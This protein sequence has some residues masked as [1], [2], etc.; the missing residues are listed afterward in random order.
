MNRIDL[1][2]IQSIKDYPCISI[3]MP[4]HR[5]HPE[6]KQD[7]IR[8]KNLIKEAEKR[9]SKELSGAETK[10][11][12]NKLN[13]LSDTIDF[14]Y[15]LDGLALFVSK[16]HSYK[17]IFP[18]PVKERV[19]IDPTF[20]TRD[21]VFAINR[22][23]PYY[24]LLLNDKLSRIFLGVRENIDEISSNGFP[25]YN[26]FIQMI[27]N[28]ETQHTNDRLQENAEK[29]KNYFREVD[30]ELRKI[31]NE[32]EYPVILAGV[33]K[34]IAVFKEITSHPE[35]VITAIKGNYDKT[36][37]LEFTRLIWPEAKRGFAEMRKQVLK[38]LD[39]SMGMK[40]AATGI[41]EVWKTANEG[42][43]ETLVVETNFQYP[44]KI[45]ESGMQLIPLKASDKI[46]SLD[47]AVDEII[48]SVISKGGKVHFVKNGELEKYGHIA[49]ILRY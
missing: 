38:Q 43:G 4:T 44:A 12:V 21:L 9:L 16:G 29:D 35:N 41:D 34:N 27:E 47:D 42:R 36:P 2:K 10:P 33:E 11:L 1:K 22:S 14:Q 18:F 17:F 49:M 48:E 26:K 24:V 5:H 40:K 8:L 6:N 19:L 39:E 20:A 23:Q 3:L 28:S 32:N 13:K 7:P 46:D 45:D 31:N 37:D 30:K 25:V 15:L